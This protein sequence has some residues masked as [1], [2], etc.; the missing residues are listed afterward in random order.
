MRAISSTSSRFFGYSDSEAL[1]AAT[2]A[3][4]AAMRSKVRPAKS[5]SGFLADLVVVTG[6]PED[7]VRLLQQPANIRLVMKDGRV[8]KDLFATLH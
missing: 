1:V 7:D 6:R 4:A 3:G 8:Y 2:R 5:R